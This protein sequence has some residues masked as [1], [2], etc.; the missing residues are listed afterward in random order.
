MFAI[1]EARAD[2]L[3][4]AGTVVEAA[5]RALPGSSGEDYL[6]Q[7]RD[8]PGRARHCPVLV[9][10][11]EAGQVVGSV[12]YVP[13]PGNPFAEVEQEGE[14]G[15]RMLGVVPAAQRRGAGRLLVE[16]CI[17]RARETRRTALVLLTSR[18]MTQAHALYRSLGFE[19]TPERDFEPVPGLRLWAFVLRL[20]DGDDER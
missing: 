4:A 19:R 8:A 16:A 17:E 10:V 3:P 1:R 9:A 18:T 14:A 13:G 5:Y 7:V 11:D 2:E 15:F 20:G 6:V 12:T